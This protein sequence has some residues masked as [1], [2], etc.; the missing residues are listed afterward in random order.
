MVKKFKCPRCGSEQWIYP[1][2]FNLCIECG[3]DLDEA[4]G[5]QKEAENPEGSKILRSVPE[6]AGEKGRYKLSFVFMVG[7]ASGIVIVVVWSLA[8]HLLGDLG[9]VIATI[10]ASGV[11]AGMSSYYRESSYERFFN[12]VIISLFSALIANAVIAKTYSIYFLGGEKL[13][14]FTF[15]SQHYI[16]ISI[17]DVLLGALIGTV[18]GKPSQQSVL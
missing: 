15:I 6:S 8:L 4:I 5:R 9:R 16:I 14:Y 13:D 11:A 18:I 12:L 10:L 1:N 17:I 3:F 2:I 7:F